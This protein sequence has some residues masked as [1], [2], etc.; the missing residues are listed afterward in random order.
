MFFR[1]IKGTFIH[2]WKKMLMI[3]LTVALGTSIATAMLNVMLDVGDKINAELKTYGANINV[4]SKSAAIVSSLYETDEATDAYLQENVTG[5]L[6]TIFWANNILDFAPFLDGQV[7][8]DGTDQKVTGTWFHYH[9]SFRKKGSDYI[10]DTGINNLRD[11]W[12]IVDGERYDE[13]ADFYKDAGDLFAIVGENVAEKKNLKAGD[14]ITLTGKTTEVVKVVGVFSS[15]DNEDDVIYLPLS[16]AQRLTG[17][18]DLIQS[19]SVSA[20]TSPED[21]TSQKVAKNP[22]LARP[23]DYELWYCTA[24]VSSICH[25][26]QEA[27]PTSS[28]SAIRR[29]ADSEGDIL[30]KTELLMTLITV[31]S[32]IGSALAISNLVTS[33]VMER[34]QELGLMK[35]IG[36]KN[37][38]IAGLVL[39][40][41]L[42]VALVGAVSG[43]F[44]GFGFAQIIG[45]TVFG[46]SI[47]MKGMVAFLVA[48]LI[49]AVTLIGSLPAIRNILR[50]RPSEVLHGR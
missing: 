13:Q 27:I 37:V 44:I 36:A 49:F 15:G 45:H 40:E 35:A 8:L 6:L 10:R 41:I 48:V 26:I 24:Y 28:A 33:S 7:K 47:D 43:Y 30:N 38:R 25:Q 12:E 46:A 29:V 22:E 23:E 11:W 1:M 21:E 34:S 31:L 32:L 3:A 39:T 20:L 19:I 18:A 4:V 14:E 50:L 42:L 9:L 16:T 5:E 17:K 2:Q